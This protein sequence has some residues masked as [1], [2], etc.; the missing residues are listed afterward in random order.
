MANK[1]ELVCVQMSFFRISSPRISVG[2]ELGDSIKMTSFMI[3]LSKVLFT[4]GL[5]GQNFCP[6]LLCL[7]D[8]LYTVIHTTQKTKEERF[9]Y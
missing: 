4:A 3:L 2:Q 5:T 6:S 8:R 9:T 1:T 7:I